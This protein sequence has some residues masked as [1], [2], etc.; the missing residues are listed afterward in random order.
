MAWIGFKTATVCCQSVLCALKD[1]SV[2]V[3]FLKDFFGLCCSESDLYVSLEQ[4]WP[5]VTSIHYVHEAWRSEV[6]FG[7]S[8]LDS[9]ASS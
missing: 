3:S 6:V 1:S 4:F 7:V 8:Y 5:V 2:Q 9:N